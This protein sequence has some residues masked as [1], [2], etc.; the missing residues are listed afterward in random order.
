MKNKTKIALAIFLAFIIIG[1]PV[2]LIFFYPD[3][4]LQ[5]FSDLNP[6]MPNIAQSDN[7]YYPIEAA[8]LAYQKPI[9]DPTEII[10][11]LT[12]APYQKSYDYSSAAKK[13]PLDDNY[14]AQFLASEDAPIKL[15]EQAEN[16]Q[17]YSNPK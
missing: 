17:S 2:F 13:T 9:H 16:L 6:T 5:D 10:A 4:Q 3:E 8:R 7:A 12:D 1:I 11:Y 14:V 15:L